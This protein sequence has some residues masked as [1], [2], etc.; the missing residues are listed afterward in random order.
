MMF[1]ANLHH[2]EYINSNYGAIRKRNHPYVFQKISSNNY[3]AKYN[4][5][6]I[7]F[8]KVQDLS[9]N[10]ISPISQNK[11]GSFGLEK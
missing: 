7:K 6:T 9:S 8:E 11:D 2:E 4:N 3:S 1:R 5:L 10:N